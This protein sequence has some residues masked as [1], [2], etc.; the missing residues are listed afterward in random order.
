MSDTKHSDPII[1]NEATQ[2]RR[3]WIERALSGVR[4]LAAGDEALPEYRE[5][6]PK[7]A[8]YVVGSNRAR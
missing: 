7:P 3:D 5:K 2:R 8:L 1:K 4:G 6:A